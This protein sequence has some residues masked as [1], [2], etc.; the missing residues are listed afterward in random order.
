MIREQEAR[1]VKK[2]RRPVTGI[3]FSIIAL[4][5]VLCK[6]LDPFPDFMAHPLEEPPD[7]LTGTR[8]KSAL[9]YK[10]VLLLLCSCHLSAR[11]RVN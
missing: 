8:S 2:S 7:F 6:T 3:G 1:G 5:P 9:L 4:F 10:P 11:D